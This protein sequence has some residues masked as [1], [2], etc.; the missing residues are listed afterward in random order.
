MTCAETI[1]LLT[2]Y[3][4]EMRWVQVFGDRIETGVFGLPD[5]SFARTSCDAEWGNDRSAGRD[6]DRR[7]THAF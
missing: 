4:I 2:E 6:V 5:G 7:M 3:P 1:D